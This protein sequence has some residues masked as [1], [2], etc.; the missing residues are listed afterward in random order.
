MIGQM[1]LS[2][3]LREAAS[4]WLKRL[5]SSLE[6]NVIMKRTM[7]CFNGCHIKSVN[8]LFELVVTQTNV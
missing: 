3:R 1:N 7:L 4:I 2:K 8:I 5:V 6:A